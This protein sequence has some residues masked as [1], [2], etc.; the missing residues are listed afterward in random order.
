MA[1][2]IGPFLIKGLLGNVSFYVAGGQHLVRRKT[3]PDREKVAT[4]PKFKRTRENAAE[5]TCARRL[6]TAI[7]RMLQMGLPQDADGKWCHRLYKLV[8]KSTGW[9]VTSPRGERKPWMGDLGLLEGYD[10]NIGRPL[11]NVF[12]AAFQ[13][14]VLE[15]ERKVR[16]EVSAFNP[17]RVQAPAGAT[18]MGFILVAGSA[19]NED[20]EAKSTIVKSELVALTA[21]QADALSLEA[22]MP[23]LLSGRIYVLMGLQFHQEVAP[24]VILKLKEKRTGSLSIVKVAAVSEEG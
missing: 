16:L 14:Q 9:D 17:P 10:M 5:F 19:H 4:S 23:E 6:T 24:G 7:G 15:Q 13:V 2:Q 18:H 1:K 22:D 11:R 3:G 20:G 21:H 12:Q 8:W